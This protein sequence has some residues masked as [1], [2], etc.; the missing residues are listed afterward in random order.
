MACTRK[1]R[2]MDR[3]VTALIQDL[4]QR[5]LLEETLVVWGGEFGRSPFREGRTAAS[6]NLG[7][8]HHPFSFTIFLAGGSVSPASATAH[9]MSLASMWATIRYMSTICK[10]RSCICWASTTPG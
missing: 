1:C 6:A 5:G 4:K 2:P 7:R 10:R 8:D 9:P 3:A